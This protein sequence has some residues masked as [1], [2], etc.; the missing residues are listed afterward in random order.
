VRLRRRASYERGELASARC[1]WRDARSV[2][3]RISGGRF[4]LHADRA[5]SGMATGLRGP[6]LHD[7]GLPVAAGEG[8]DVL[9]AGSEVHVRPVEEREG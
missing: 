7:Q 3:R 2:G 8:G 1:P 4:G 9:L 5:G 6:D